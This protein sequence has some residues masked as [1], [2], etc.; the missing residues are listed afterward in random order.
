MSKNTIRVAI[1]GPG[2]AG[3]STVAKLVAERE[4]I[5]Y[6]DTGAM[7][8]ALAFKLINS[9]IDLSEI[10][11]LGLKSSD[12]ISKVLADTEIDYSQGITRLDGVDI[13]DEIRKPEI[14]IAASSVS[15]LPEVREKLV[16]LQRQMADNKSLVMDGRDIGSNVLKDAE[17]KIFL[18]ASP[19]ERAKRRYEEMLSKGERIE[20]ETVLSDMIARDE[21]DINRELNPL[22]KATD[23]IEVD[24]S[25]LTVEQVVDFI[26]GMIEKNA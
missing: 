14:S 11:N 10:G 12:E 25:Q 4:N 18:T 1:D 9:G 20:Y 13:S 2:G 15:A 24:S 8:R 23:A 19:E 16:T 3:K 7:Y 26:C 21:K 6:I 17:L 22:V 5:D